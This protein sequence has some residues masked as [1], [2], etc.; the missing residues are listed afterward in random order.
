MVKHLVYALCLQS[1]FSFFFFSQWHKL[2][3]ISQGP[4]LYLVQVVP[5]SLYSILYSTEPVWLCMAL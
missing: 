3:T 2:H 1:I 4:L 5:F